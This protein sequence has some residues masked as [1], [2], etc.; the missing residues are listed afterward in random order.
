MQSR[1]FRCFAV[2]AALMAGP[3]FAGHIVPGLWETT[4]EPTTPEPYLEKLPPALQAKMKAASIVT[5][6]L[7]VTPQQAA[8]DGFVF[9]RT[10][11]CTVENIQPFA[12]RLKADV[13]CTRNQTMLTTHYQITYETPKRYTGTVTMDVVSKNAQKSRSAKLDAHFV[14]DDCGAIKPLG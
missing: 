9:S 4:S 11:D 10:S 13:V 14:S 6:R 3:A 7:C 5:V 12:N 1:P 8:R 2:A